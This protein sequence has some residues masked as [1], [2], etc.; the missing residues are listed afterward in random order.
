MSHQPKWRGRNL[1]H[2]PSGGDAVTKRQYL[3]SGERSGRAVWTFSFFSTTAPF[4]GQ[5]THMKPVFSLSSHADSL[6]FGWWEVYQSAYI[7]LSL[8]Q[9]LSAASN[10]L[11]SDVTSLNVCL[12]STVAAGKRC[13]TSPTC[14]SWLCS[15]CTCCQHC[16]ATSPSM[17]RT[18]IHKSVIMNSNHRQK[19]P[20]TDR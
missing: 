4:K 5:L 18:S 10:L 12:V 9:V 16:L 14:P 1:R 11:K 17:V 20:Q 6:L 7:Y 19:R 8:L 15:S 2:G 13:R 3:M